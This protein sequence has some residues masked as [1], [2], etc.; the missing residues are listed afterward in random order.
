MLRAAS[1]PKRD[2]VTSINDFR[3]MGYTA[4][5]IANCYD[6]AGLVCA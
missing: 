3:T 6:P 2:G 5:A 1:S 4:E